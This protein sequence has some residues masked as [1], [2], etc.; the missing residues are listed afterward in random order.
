MRKIGEAMDV[1][2]EI[3][4]GQ[5]GAAISP[6]ARSIL[7]KQYFLND[8]E[9]NTG[10]ASGDFDYVVIG[11]SFGAL[12]FIEEVLALAPHSRILVIERGPLFFPD[13]F[14][15]LPLSF[16]PLCRL[17]ASSPW[18]L[19][20]KTTK[21]EFI[22]SIYGLMPFFGGRSTYWSAWAP[23]P[24]AADLQGWPP[25]IK[26][27][28]EKKFSKAALCLNILGFDKLNP[29][30]K[31]EDGKN[32]D[33]GLL[34]GRLHAALQKQV[35]ALKK[36]VRLEAAP[37]AM[38][39][40]TNRMP[41]KC[42]TPHR[43]FSCVNRQ[44]VLAQSNAG[45]L[46]SVVSECTVEKITHDTNS[47]G[48]TRA[49]SLQTSR[50]NVRLGNAKLILAMGTLPATTLVANSFAAASFPQLKNLGERLSGHSTSVIVAR[51]P[52]ETFDF[53][54]SLPEGALAAF[55]MAGN[56]KTS[57][58]QYHTQFIVV[59]DQHS[60]KNFESI[61]R[62]APELLDKSSYF[63][64]L[65]CREHVMFVC[66]ALGELDHRNT[67]NWFRKNDDADLTQN[68]T[69]QI[70]LNASD[71]KTWD[72]M[73]QATFEILE[74]SFTDKNGHAA[75]VEYW[76][77]TQT[78]GTWVAERP[79]KHEIRKSGVAHEASTLWLG[80]DNDLA[81]PVD[82]GFKLRGVENVYVTGG[83]LLPTA[84]SWNPTGVIV[85]LA[86]ELA[87]ILSKSSP[88]P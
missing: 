60:D 24:T 50:G 22:R 73:E 4:A 5:G 37:I 49:T 18:K 34:Q 16:Q 28:I 11:S 2:T 20:E 68:S 75:K 80:D 3:H 45:S 41:E 54:R 14:H 69:A 82:T 15:N 43:L 79:P 23:K 19:S 85:L 42:S 39:R 44:K 8:H 87:A 86:Q 88:H 78:Q 65:S 21:G 6:T 71:L 72:A 38:N 61:A 57:G 29:A 64:I 74:G 32:P 46:L 33:H 63:Q 1:R 52:R 56:E 10:F 58:L 76:H 84:G 36:Y 47:H 26:D 67:E 59:A 81:S 62:N 53:E 7:E 48:A 30:G 77:G 9:V 27:L 66:S 31:S 13:H 40:D 51:I 83:G 12:A 35:G 17:S 55:Y 70:V 25:A